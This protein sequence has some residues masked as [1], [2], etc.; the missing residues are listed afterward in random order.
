MIGAK[1]CVLVTH[2]SSY[3]RQ[4]NVA[5]AVPTWAPATTANPA[6]TGDA[7]L[8]RLPLAQV[9]LRA[10]LVRL[11]NGHLTEDTAMRSAHDWGRAHGRPCRSAT[12]SRWP[13][14]TFAFAMAGVAML[15]ACD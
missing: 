13:F 3:A 14:H 11:P 10:T 9:H 1:G 4:Q 7:K 8:W 12:V 5:T 2:W 6:K 15:A